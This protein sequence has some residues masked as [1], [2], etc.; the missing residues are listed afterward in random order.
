MIGLL[1]LLIS[2]FSLGNLFFKRYSIGDCE[3]YEGICVKTG[4][5]LG[6][7]CLLLFFIGLV[8]LLYIWL[9]TLLGILFSV[10]LA[11]SLIKKKIWRTKPQLKIS[12]GKFELFSFLG[13]AIIGITTFLACFA[14]VTGAIVN[15]E[16][17]THLSV[18]KA[19]LMNHAVCELGFQVSYLAGNGSL[20]FLLPMGYSEAG[21]K[22]FNWVCMLGCAMLL[23]DFT[24]RITDKKTAWFAGF[25]MLINPVIFR[26]SFIGFV[27]LPAVFFNLLCFLTLL[28]YEQ[29]KKVRTIILAAFF[30][31]IAVGV[32]PTNY[33]YAPV[34][35]LLLSYI[36]FT[37]TEQ[38][39]KIL[40]KLTIFFFI[41]AL[42]GSIWPVRTL[43]N[44]G[45]PTVPPPK[46]IYSINGNK[47]L[48]ICGKEMTKEH[49]ESLYRYY[50]KR[51]EKYGK[52]IKNFFLLPW[53]LTMYPESFSVGDS[54]GTL[55]L[56]L[57]PLLFIIAGWPRW[58][59]LFL[60][61]GVTGVTSVYFLIFPEGRYFIP[62]FVTLCPLCAWIFFKIIQYKIVSPALKTL[63]FC[64]LVFCSLTSLRLTADE[65]KT[66]FNSDARIEYITNQTPFTETFT[67]LDSIGV[68]TI[69]VMYESPLFYYLSSDYCVTEDILDSP[70]QYEGDYILDIDYSQTIEKNRHSCTQDYIINEKPDILQ[71]IF[72][73][74]DAKVYQVK[75]Q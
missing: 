44:T 26:A 18:P 57:L 68:K 63:W 58:V 74:P 54:I 19:W 40:L 71:L 52:G 48:I 69:H 75:R 23:F 60:I 5:G 50:S 17:A 7:W 32:K 33:F 2:S 66:L 30:L 47:P 21:P 70:E 65:I 8:H 15:D 14:P 1:I 13:I 67:F 31:G 37:N 16:I 61:F 22:L 11:V 39:R 51:V 59:F 34:F 42:F 4:F 45:S 62:I 6:I 46:F 53:N 27:D 56:T 38:K 12:F 20:L 72:E 3:G 25:F 41:T 10:P 29:I 49:V 28:S 9:L 43:V 36:L 73:G 55:Y 24:S 64:N 35:F